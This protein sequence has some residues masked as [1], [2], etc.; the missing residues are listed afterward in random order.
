MAIPKPTAH[1]TRRRRPLHQRLKES[2]L[3]ILAVLVL[4]TGGL[5]AGIW[6]VSGVLSG[7]GSGLGAFIVFV[8]IAAF[9]AL[10]GLAVGVDLAR[11]K[12]REAHEPGRS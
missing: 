3:F 4:G 5:V 7:K 10:I 12:W 6:W 8:V 2:A 9:F 11:A 1:G